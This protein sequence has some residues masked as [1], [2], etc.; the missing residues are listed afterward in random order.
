MRNTAQLGEFPISHQ[1][2]VVEGISGTVAELSF[3]V[4]A[5]G[6]NPSTTTTVADQNF[7]FRWFCSVSEVSG[8]TVRADDFFVSVSVTINCWTYWVIGALSESDV[9]ASEQVTA[10][11][12]PP[13]KFGYDQTTVGRP[14]IN[15]WIYVKMN[16]FATSA[17]NATNGSGANTIRVVSKS[18]MY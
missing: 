1:C 12:N 2:I 10:N 11:V 5:R 18:P 3:G 14:G 17:L 8:R 15:V 9:L 4:S 7:S 13:V 16:Q 6:G